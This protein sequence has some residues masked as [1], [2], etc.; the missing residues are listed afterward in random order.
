ML[1]VQSKL[2]KLLKVT[3][4]FSKAHY[5]CI[6]SWGIIPFPIVLLFICPLLTIA[7][8]VTKIPLLQAK[9][10]TGNNDEYKEVSYDDSKWENQKLGDVWQS[11]SH[12]NYHRYA[13][14]RVH[15]VIPSSLVAGA[16]WKDSLRTSV[17]EDKVKSSAEALIDKGLINHGWSYINVDDG[18]EAPRRAADGTIATNEKFQNMKRLGNFLHDNG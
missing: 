1:L 15:V 17:S 2:R 5:I 13:W 10:R 9:F 14:Y 18:W 3:F 11:Q 8:N 6:L 12:A 4:Q 7:Q 16:V